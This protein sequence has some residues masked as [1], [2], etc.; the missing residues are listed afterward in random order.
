MSSEGVATLRGAY[1]AF[2]RQDIAAVMAAFDENIEWS[3]PETLP[4][5]GEYRG[6]DSV[7]GFFGKLPQYWDSLSVEPTE[8]IDGGD[9]I[10]AV[11]RVQ[12]T[13]AAGEM[14]ADAVHLWRMRSGKAVSFREFSDTALALRAIG[15]PVGVGD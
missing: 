13:G 5:G 6:H 15:Q 14:S 2:K 1:D 4:F 7:A 10:L 8:L 12:G 3:V 11:V 9:A